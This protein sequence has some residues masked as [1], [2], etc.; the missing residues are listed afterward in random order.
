MH[1]KS[2]T[3]LDEPSPLPF[4]SASLTL[5]SLTWKSDG[6]PPALANYS[7]DGF[8]L[9]FALPF[10]R[11]GVFIIYSDLCF[12]RSPTGA[13]GFCPFAPSLQSKALP[14]KLTLVLPPECSQGP[15]GP[16]SLLLDGRMEVS[17]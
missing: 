11:F 3:P 15:F 5:G 8:R 9:I 2:H 13:R 14:A 10:L 7:P 17:L 4:R 16:K 12:L 1:D 6:I